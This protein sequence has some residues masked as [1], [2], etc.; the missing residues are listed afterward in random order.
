MAGYNAKLLRVDLTNKTITDYPLDKKLLEDF[1]GGAGLACRIL[2]PMV[3]KNTDPL[4]PKNPLLIMA[5]PLSGTNVPSAGR[6]SICAKSPLTRIWGESSFG[7]S[8][9]AELRYAGYD[10]IMLEGKAQSLSYLLIQDNLVEIKDASHLKGQETFT[11]QD[12]IR[13]ELNNDKL[14]IICIGPAGENLV[15]YASIVHPDVRTAVAGR[16]GMG[17][18]MG[19]KHLK[20]IA[21]EGTHK[22]IPVADIDKL[23]AQST[24][25]AKITMENFGSQMFQTLGTAGYVD[26]ANATGDLST[27]YYTQPEFPDAYNISGA[28]MQEKIL[29]KNTGC[30]RC[31][32]RCGREIEIK[33][34]KYEIPLNPGPEYE[35]LASLGSNLLIGDLEAISYLGLLCDRL[36]MDTISS[37]VTMAFSLFLYEKGILSKHETGGLELKWGDPELIE[38]LLNMIATRQGFGDLLAEG[39]QRFAEKFEIS[40]DEVAAV[41]GLELPFHDVRAYF[42]MA[43]AYATSPRGACHNQ[44]DMFL[45]TIGNIGP[46]VYPLGVEPTDRFQSEGKAKSVAILQDYRAIYNS[47]IMCIFVNPPPDQIIN[48]LNYATGLTYDLAALKRTGERIINMKRLF[49]IKM[50]LTAKDDRLPRHVLE[51]L[52]G[53]LERN[54]PDLQ[55]QL[56]EYYE[57]RAWDPATG[58]PSKK[59][60]QELGLTEFIPDIWG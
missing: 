27:K 31:P 25:I 41:N 7:G 43:I 30:F 11:T 26:M 39:T 53:P 58:K 32:I 8:F 51:P 28:T 2:Y 12:S 6:T 37:G 35:T 50:G 34:G 48:A 60:L 29:V 56:K 22:D 18:L 4:S 40:Q 46:G 23:K 19:S 16:T 24:E 13:Q 49:N 59:K 36:G 44:A 1:I 10:G 38:K 47:L 14:K 17:A 5:G 55:L 20:A 33:E 3:E 9:A 45:A 21:V 52:E 57:F 42:G 15:K 54:V